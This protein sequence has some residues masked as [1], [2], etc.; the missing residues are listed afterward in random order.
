MLRGLAWILWLALLGCALPASVPESPVAQA[1][2]A[3]AWPDR[4]QGET[5]EAT[6]VLVVDGD[7][8]RVRMDGRDHPVRYIGIDTPET[9]PDQPPEPYGLAASDANR[10]LLREGSL[11]LERDVSE[12]DRF[13][14]LLR[15]VWVV[16][17]VGTYTL[18]NRE[19]LL[20]GFARVTTHPPDV[21]YVEEFLA[22]ERQARAAERG[23]WGS[24]R[25]ST[26]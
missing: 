16:D 8:I 10:R 26:P 12:T 24:R 4:P 6:L 23:L 9:L 13:G 5:H 2:E 3:P 19:L 20:G 22:A 11:V 21:R 18:L 15:Y 14:R 25:G 1:A 17:D 7:T